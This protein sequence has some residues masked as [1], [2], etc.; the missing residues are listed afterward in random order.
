MRKLIVF[1]TMALVAFATQVPR[2]VADV[3]I[4][5]PP[6]GKP[7]RVKDYRGKTVL[8]AIL[9][10]ECST[11]AASVEILNGIQRDYGRRGVQVLAAAVNEGAISLIGPFIQRYRPT[12]PMGVLSRDATRRLADFTSEER[13]FV[14]IFMIVDSGGTV[15]FQAYGDS[16]FFKNED[17]ETR[18]VLDQMLK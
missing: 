16:E 8:I 9:N 17:R 7:I 11:C 12:F 1:L 18:K 3:T 6:G 15:R 13:P 2:S 5:P 4:D 14:P 10:T